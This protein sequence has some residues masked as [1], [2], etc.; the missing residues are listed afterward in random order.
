MVALF[1]A[2]GEFDVGLFVGVAFLFVF[3]VFLIFSVA[4][5]G[6]GFGDDKVGHVDFVLE[7][8]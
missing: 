7:E 1:H 8:R 4:F 3:F 5:F 6:E 2:F